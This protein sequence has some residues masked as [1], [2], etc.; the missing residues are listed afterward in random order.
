MREIS[1]PALFE[2]PDLANTADI[3]FELAASQPAEAAFSRLGP[4]SV[5]QDISHAEFAGDVAALARGLIGAGVAP[6]DRVVLNGDGIGEKLFGGLS[7]RARVR[8]DA[9]VHLPASLTPARAAAIGTAGFTAMIG[10]LALE[11]AGVTP[12]D[13]PVLVTGA[14]GGVAFRAVKPCARCVIIATDQET[15]ERARDREPLR[16]LAGFRR[17]DR[18]KVVF[19]QNLVPDGAGRIAVGDRVEVVEA[20][21]EFSG[22]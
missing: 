20:S 12:A 11:D 13:G 5:W 16:T 2:C 8:P 17:D 19:G 22:T 21:V 14:A 1:V 7:Q 18:G 10:A 6:G 15:G 3:V 9:L 4:D